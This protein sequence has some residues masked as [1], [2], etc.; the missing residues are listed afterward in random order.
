MTIYSLNGKFIRQY[1][2]DEGYAPY[3]QTTSAIEW[4]LKNDK[5]E[6]VS[7]GVYM[8][9]VAVPGLGER[10]IKWMGVAR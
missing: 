10:T 1:N 2:R 7:S 3:N 5:S 9:H 4:D 8:I 6:S